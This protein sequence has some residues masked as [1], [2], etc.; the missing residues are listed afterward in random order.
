VQCTDW[1]DPIKKRDGRFTIEENKIM[2]DSL[3][4]LARTVMVVNIG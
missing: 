2:K 4:C 1:A 3:G